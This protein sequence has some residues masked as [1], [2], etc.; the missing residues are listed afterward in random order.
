[1]AIE[2]KCLFLYQKFIKHVEFFMACIYLEH[3]YESSFLKVSPFGDN[4]VIL[5]YMLYYSTYIIYN[6]YVYGKQTHNEII[7]HSPWK[8]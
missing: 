7:F 6:V 4:K 5:I 3:F 1:M 8:P 2:I